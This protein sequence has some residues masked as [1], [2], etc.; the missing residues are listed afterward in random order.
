MVLTFFRVLR[1]PTCESPDEPA[2][3][4]SLKT[5][6]AASTPYPLPLAA[7]GAFWGFLGR[8]GTSGAF[9]GFGA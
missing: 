3:P 8:F 1:K 7:P 9:G 6:K 5:P 4:D 2:K